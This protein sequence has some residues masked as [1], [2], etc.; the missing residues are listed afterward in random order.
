MCLGLGA[1]AAFVGGCTTEPHYGGRTRP[2]P[3][4]LGPQDLREG[5]GVRGWR[6]PGWAGVPS[7]DKTESTE[8]TLAA[9]GGM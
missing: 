8:A 3:A 6:A 2:N 1:K 9:V 4:E 5:Q 7:G